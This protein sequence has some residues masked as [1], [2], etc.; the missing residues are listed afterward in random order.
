MRI[1]LRSLDDEAESVQYT[2]MRTIETYMT[3]EDLLEGVQPD[4]LRYERDF[5][6]LMSAIMAWGLFWQF[7]DREHEN[8]Y[9]Q[10]LVWTIVFVAAWLTDNF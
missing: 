4:D 10:F 7:A 8:Q 9:T 3:M 1:F 5:F 2:Y 6:W